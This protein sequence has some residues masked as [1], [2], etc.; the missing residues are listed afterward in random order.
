[1]QNGWRQMNYASVRPSADQYLGWLVSVSKR[2]PFNR[3]LAAIVWLLA[4]AFSFLWRTAFITLPALLFWNIYKKFAA[5]W[6]RD[7]ADG[8]FEPAWPVAR[9][10][11]VILMAT[12]PTWGLCM[13]AGVVL[14]A[15]GD[16]L[17][18]RIARRR[19]GGADYE[20]S[21]P[22]DDLP[23][24]STQRGHRSH[25]LRQ[26]LFGRY[27]LR[28]VA[29]CIFASMALF[30]LYL[31][32]TY[33]LPG[34]YRYRPDI[35]TALRVP[36]PS[37]YHDGS[38][39]FIAVIL[40]NSMGVLPRWIREFNKVIQ[41]LG[42]DNVF[43]SVVE[44]NSGDG[45]PEMLDEWKITLD[46]MGVKNLIRTRDSTIVRP[47]DMS[48][49][50]PRIRFLSDTRNLALAPL[51]E[52]GG[53]DTVLFSNDIFIEAESVVELLK[54]KEGEWDMVCGLDLGR[55]GM[56]DA[57]VLRDRLGRLVSSLWPYFL[58]DA[59]MD[60][61]MEEEPAPV[62]TCW[63][64]IVAFR[65]DPI[66]PVSLRTPGRLSTSPLSRPLPE[67]HPTYPQNASLT[68]AQTPPIKFRVSEE[69]ECFS[70]ESFLFPYDLRRQF[71]M[72]RIYVNPRV[73]NS[74]E[75]KHYWWYKYVTR[76]WMVDWWIK[77]WERGSGMQ[78]AKMVVG[79]RKKVWNWDGG[80]CHPWW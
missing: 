36:K 65:A 1:M 67:T 73:I 40:N 69:K 9:T 41:Y 34:D 60:A 50:T 68:P 62:F 15:F 54:T 23:N 39:V 25:S 2:P 49:A 79:D 55:W 58:E 3:I 61:V 19:R 71:D 45:T 7:Y 35:E 56:Y 75:W 66:L 63:N 8:I 4:F 22:M 51:V 44:S 20:M 24:A 29:F 72:Q 70:S 12:I 18:P 6:T 77:N 47:D 30:G 28:T 59:G 53:Y 74:Y 38:K 57:W 5:D 31:Y 43:I 13:A 32:K 11:L 42:T 14:W 80:E 76:H 64:G 78:F 37:G 26:I 17:L 33:E 16:F 27:Y 21:I 46:K 10:R 48:T 52:Q